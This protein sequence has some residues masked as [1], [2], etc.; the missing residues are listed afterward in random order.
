MKK[1]SEF[2]QFY[3][4]NLLGFL[5]EFDKKRSYLMNIRIINLLLLFSMIPIGIGLMS[6]SDGE[7]PLMLLLLLPILV[8]I[9]I[10][11]VK[12]HKRMQL[13][14]A[15]YKNEVIKKIVT[16]LDP[17]LNFEYQ[18]R[19]SD[20]EFYK[21][22]I[23]LTSAD[24]SKGEDL[25]YGKLDK[26]EI[27]FSELHLEYK[28]SSTDSNGN[29]NDQWHTIFKGIFFI[30]DF[31]KHFQTETVV[32][33]DGLEKLF[34]KFAR[35]LQK[36]ST[37][38]G[39]LIQLENPEFEKYFKVYADDPIESRYILSPALMERIVEFRKKSNIKI[40]LSF[41]DSKIY[42]A[43]PITKDLFEPRVFNNNYDFEFIKESFGYL[44]L[45]TSIVDEMNLNTRIWT[46]E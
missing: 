16:F 34:G 6:F 7:E 27:M 39:K 2:R 24:R 32:L 37:R 29:R 35:S 14:R 3:E 8:V 45:F 20:A 4:T 46:K 12:R 41:I 40:S 13:F 22:K 21:S 42:M 28:T 11:A 19:I 44:L 5:K 26:T 25:I 1:E 30:A 36:I 38:K 9:I 17:N 31:N 18:N 33:P 15:E 23:F 43:L 10:L